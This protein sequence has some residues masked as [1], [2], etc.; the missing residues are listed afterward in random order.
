[1]KT[2]RIPLVGSITNRNPNAAGDDTTDQQF[3]NCFPE[4]NSNP[5]TGKQTVTLNKRQ[6]VAASADV[7]VG[8][9]GQYGSIVWTSNSATE[10]PIIFSFLKTASTV[11]FY[12]DAS[13]QIGSDVSNVGACT[14]MSETDI[15][16]TG[17]LV[18]TMVDNPNLTTE[19]WFFPE[20]GAWT[21]ITDGDFPS[22]AT[23]THAHMDGYMFVMGASGRIYHSD[24]NSLSAWGAASFITANQFGDN[25]V[26]L[27][28]YKN[29]IVGFGDY[30]IEFFYN[31]G[32]AVGSVLSRVD[33]ATIRIGAMRTTNLQP[34]SMR[35]IGNT[36]YWVGASMD[37]GAKGV[38]RFNGMQA[39]KISTP[40]IDKLCANSKLVYPLGGISLLGMTHIVFSGGNAAN[41]FCYCIEAKFWW[42]LSLAGSLV[43]VS[44][45]GGV[46]SNFSKSY[47]LA[48]STAKIYSFNPNSP[49]WQDNASS[50]T[51]T[52]QT[53]NM[54]LDTDRK[55]YW[56]RIRVSYDR[57]SAASN[58]GIA[59]SDDDHANYSAARNIDMNTNQSWLGGL[60]ASRRRSWKFTHAANTPCRVRAVEIDY[61]PGSP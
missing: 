56:K 6:G 5:T 4:I 41:Q 1:M 36:V 35:A 59:W 16:G 23:V 46:D 24:L 3:V 60:G 18:A 22:D 25:G 55:K 37:T 51:M 28:R 61:L 11:G 39:E 29:F 8:A 20:G 12:N 53:E 9:T 58:F 38:Y 49:V 33:N 32:N 13:S 48:S 14:F 52:V 27:A 21:Q 45:V 50:Y 43:I 10:P 17:N 42:Q 15:S 54:D 19:F 7:A 57:Q 30:S 2:L 31:A 44:A 47:L 26:G 34:P 40:A